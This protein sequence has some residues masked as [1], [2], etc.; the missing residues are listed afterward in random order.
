[1]VDETDDCDC[2]ECA[3]NRRREQISSYERD[4]F[5]GSGCL[6]LLMA[7]VIIV[8]TIVICLS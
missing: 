7:A 1:M 8:T 6:T 2:E 5:V 3:Y 4:F